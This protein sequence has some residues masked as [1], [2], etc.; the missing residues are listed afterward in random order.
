MKSIYKQ[1][2]DPAILKECK[3]FI[4]EYKDTVNDKEIG[5][6]AIHKADRLIFSLTNCNDI[7]EM[8]E[9]IRSRKEKI[10]L[11]EDDFNPE[12]IRL[13]QEISQIFLSYSI[14]VEANKVIKKLEEIQD[15]NWK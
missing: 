15:K 8:N 3:E 13:Y 14:D 4:E 1:K 9:E 7:K 5:K 11:E 10:L 2:A 6:E 12:I